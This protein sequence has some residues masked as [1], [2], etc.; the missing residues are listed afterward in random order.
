MH[1]RAEPRLRRRGRRGRRGPAGGPRACGR[2][3]RRTRIGLI[4]DPGF[5]FGKTPEQNLGSA[6]GLG[7]AARPGPA[8]PAGHVAQVHARQGAGPAGR[9]APRGDAGATALGIA[10]GA[11]IVRV[12]DVRA[13]VR[14]ARVSD[15][16][17]R[18]TWRESSHPEVRRER[19]DR[20]RRTC[21][22][23]PPRRP[24]LGARE[25]QPFEVDVEL[26]RRPAPGRR[27]SDDL[28]ATIDYG[29]V[30]DERCSAILEGPPD[31]VAGSRSPRR[32]PGR[33][34]R[35]LGRDEVVVR[36]RKPGR[37]ARRPARPRRASRSAAPVLAP[38]ATATEGRTQD[39]GAARRPRRRSGR[40][41]FAREP[42]EV[43]RTRPEGHLSVIVWPSRRTV[44][45]DDVAWRELAEGRVERVLVVE[46]LVADLRDDVAVLDAG[47]RRLACRS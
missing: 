31:P 26:R 9:R 47:V 41:G 25:A 32:S 40:G 30:Y 24:R 36:V 22:S 13:N 1:N 18:G 8:D 44:D 4:V 7:R 14:A 45:L 34:S 21:A 3:R 20:P 43:G 35:D 37:P 12:H 6:G 29:P 19:S 27:R 28:A 39:A 2:P 16:I 33:C 38:R 5:G 23:G 46:D 42:L 11:D 15:A 10:A 17:V